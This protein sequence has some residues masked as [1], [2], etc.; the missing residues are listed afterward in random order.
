MEKDQRG[1]ETVKFEVKIRR[2]NNPRWKADPYKADNLKD[3]RKH[4]AQTITKHGRLNKGSYQLSLKYKEGYGKDEDGR[5]WLI[6]WEGT[7]EKAIEFF[8]EYVQKIEE[9]LTEKKMNDKK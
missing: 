2:V 1:K 9:E 3:V 4:L 6:N 5:T 8:S 7:P